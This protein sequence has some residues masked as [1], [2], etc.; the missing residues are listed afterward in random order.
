MVSKRVKRKIVFIKDNMS[1]DIDFAITRIWTHIPF[2]LG[3][4]TYENTQVLRFVEKGKKTQR[5][6]LG[7]R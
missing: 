6:V 3:T 2:M 1:I 7:M 5:R 4:I